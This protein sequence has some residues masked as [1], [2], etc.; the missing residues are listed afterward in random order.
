MLLAAL[1]V[2]LLAVFSGCGYGKSRMPRIY[3]ETRAGL[4]KALAEKQE[5]IYVGNMEFDESDIPIA[6]KNSVRI[7]GRQEGSVL[8][9]AH[10]EVIGAESE[11]HKIEVTFE[12]IIFDGCYDMPDVDTLDYPSF[13]DL[14]GD[15]GDLLAVNASGF[16]DLSLVSCKFTRY[17]RKLIPALYVNYSGE[18][19]GEASSC[20]IK[21]CVFSENICERGVIW[22]NGKGAALDFRDS[23]VENNWIH[24]NAVFV[25]GMNG[26]ISGLQIRNNRRVVFGE[27]NIYTHSGGGIL[28]S[29][30]ELFVTGCTIE[31]NTSINGGGMAISACNILV[32]DSVIRNNHALECGGGLIIGSSESAPVYIT[33]CLIERNTAD[34][35]EGGAMVWPDDQINIGLPT[36]IVEFSFC[37]FMGNTSPDPEHLKYHPIAN[38]D[39]EKTAGRDGK[40]DFIACRIDDSAVDAA[41]INSGKFNIVNSTD[42]GE[43]VPDEL[44][45]SVARGSYADVSQELFPGVNAVVNDDAFKH[46][47]LWMLSAAGIIVLLVASVFI[48]KSREALVSSEDEADEEASDAP[49]ESGI[50]EFSMD[51][52][53]PEMVDRARNYGVLTERE[54]DIL[55]EYL[56]GKKR[57]QIAEELFIS[58]STVKNH[59]SR[60]F[61]K[62]EVKSKEELEGKL[63]GQ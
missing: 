2:V 49:E 17:C 38:E 7:I 8:S 55:C 13:E 26:T 37:T 6:V 16:L 54:L 31:G 21:N 5:E 61:S 32:S 29:K 50:V 10:F 19:I 36:G 47:V 35:L 51:D 27:K 22:F 45:S 28:L 40:T 23:I 25:G 52:V 44:V 14:H 33:N 59:I 56:K 34:K 58:E 11:S 57:Q 12:N 3:V 53:V 39:P 30:S 60:I 63:M 62:L 20:T 18:G 46:P 9:K 48:R 1:A 4:M 15:R 24:T 43:P 41:I 42:K